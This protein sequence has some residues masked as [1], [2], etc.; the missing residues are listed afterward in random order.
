MLSRKSTPSPGERFRKVCESLWGA[1]ATNTAIANELGYT[2]G[3]IRKWAAG[4]PLS[5]PAL[6]ILALLGVSARYLTHGE[7]EMFLPRG[8]PAMPREISGDLYDYILM[9]EELRALLHHFELEAVRGSMPVETFGEIIRETAKSLA[10]AG[11]K[12]KRG[13]KR[14]NAV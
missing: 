9:L 3:A 12:A 1:N 2:E 4:A 5:G 14:Q 7:G 6:K 8:N 10:V 11:K 13:K